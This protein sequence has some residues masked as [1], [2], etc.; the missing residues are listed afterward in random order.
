MMHFGRPTGRA[1]LAPAAIAIVLCFAATAPAAR[2]ANMTV[3]ILND[4]FPARP[5]DPDPQYLAQL[6]GRAGRRA[7]LVS[8]DDLIRRGDWNP[9]QTPVLVIPYGAMFPGVLKDPL[10]RYVKAGGDLVIIGGYAFS[11]ILERKEGRW[12]VD[13]SLGPKLRINTRWGKPFDVLIVDRENQLGMFDA[14]FQLE[15]VRRVTAN[16]AALLAGGAAYARDVAAEGFAATGVLGDNVVYPEVHARHLPLLMAYDRFGRYRGPAGALILNHDGPF[17][18]SRWAVFGVDN[19][20]LFPSGDEAAAGLFIGVLDALER[21]YLHTLGTQYKLY[22]PGETVELAVR[23]A[24]GNEGSRFE[25]A[26]IRVEFAVEGHGGPVNATIGEDG[27]A[28]ARVPA[29]ASDEVGVRRVTATLF[30][31][32]RAIDRLTAGLAVTPRLLTANGDAPP[33]G[34]SA[35]PRLTYRN[36]YFELDGVP[37]P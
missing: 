25:K 2:E 1:A 29:P 28:A 33:A 34:A 27:V 23:V 13:P 22:Q 36:N 18:N 26:P 24:P 32:E 3:L 9:A 17:R 19:A 8:T 35:A 11:D 21:P 16:P 5:A 14:G 15:Q 30:E 31:G 37:T 10:L 6:V 7:E 20:N 12:Q 4:S